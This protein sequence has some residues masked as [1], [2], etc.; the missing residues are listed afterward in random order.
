VRE[1][2]RAP[3]VVSQVWYKVGSSYETPGQTGLSHALEHMMFKG[4][5]KVGPG[6]ASLILRDLG[7]EENAFT[8]DDSPPI[9]RCWPATAWAAFELEADR[10]AS[11]RLPAD[12]FSREI[13]VIKEE[14]RLRTDDKPMSKAYELQG[15]GLPGQRLPHADHRLD[16]RPDRMKV[17][18]LRHW[19]NPGTCRTT[20]PWW[21]SATSPRRSEDPPSATSARSPSATC[22]RRSCRWNWPSP[23]SA[24]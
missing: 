20:P 14:R 18:E 15:H 6:E 4:S 7:A 1:D 11:L 10:M 16:G 22:R 24:S 13:E 3:V 8:S 19:Y 9:T 12:E 21:W 5:E 23:A 17:E 2:H